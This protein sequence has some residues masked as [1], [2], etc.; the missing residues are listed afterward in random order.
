M[1]K[2]V[3]KP[4]KDALDC[5]LWEKIDLKNVEQVNRKLL[6]S[7]IKCIKINKFIKSCKKTASNNTGCIILQTTG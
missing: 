5:I 7:D 1:D 2:T 4:I 3:S 6:W